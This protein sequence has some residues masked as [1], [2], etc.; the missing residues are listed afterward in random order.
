[1]EALFNSHAMHPG[2]GARSRSGRETLAVTSEVVTFADTLSIF[3]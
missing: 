1:M 2:Y 3:A